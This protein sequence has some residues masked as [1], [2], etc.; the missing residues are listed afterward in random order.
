QTCA[1]PISA[2]FA[3]PSDPS[4]T[5]SGLQVGTTILV[6]TVNNGPCDTDPVYDAMGIFIYDDQAPA[7]DAGPDQQLCT[8]QTSTTLAGSAVVHPATG[9][10]TLVSGSGTIVDPNDPHTAVTDLGV[11][12]NTFRWTVINGV[13]DDAITFDEVNIVVFDENNPLADAGPD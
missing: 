5:V 7:A 9:Q 2:V 3:D 10:W 13:C 11:G 8:P 1:L 6:W 4:T 12:V